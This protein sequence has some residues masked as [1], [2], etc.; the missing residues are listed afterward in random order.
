MSKPVTKLEAERQRHRQIV[1]QCS[2]LVDLLDQ[3][4]VPARTPDFSDSERE[5]WGKAGERRLVDRLLKLRA[6]ASDNTK[7]LGG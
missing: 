1:Q 4:L 5:V 6:E 2:A 3:V 7:L